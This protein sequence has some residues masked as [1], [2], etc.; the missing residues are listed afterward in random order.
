[1]PP[2]PRTYR[3]YFLAYHNYLIRPLVLI[4]LCHE[5]TTKPSARRTPAASHT[6]PSV[7]SG[8]LLDATLTKIITIALL[9]G[10]DLYY[11]TYQHSRSLVFSFTSRIHHTIQKLFPSKFPDF[12]SSLQPERPPSIAAKFSEY[13]RNDWPVQ[14]RYTREVRPLC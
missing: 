10:N 5:E 2:S 7:S 8:S 6:W 14:P 13:R 1:M 9:P 11:S 4:L 3:Y 12:E